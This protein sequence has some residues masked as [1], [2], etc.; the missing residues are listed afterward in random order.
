M[1]QKYQ[2]KMFA[3][4]Y[5]YSRSREEAE[6]TFHEGFMKV[7]DN[8][9]SFAKKGSLEGWI[10]K[11]MV[12]TAIEKYRKGKH[13]SFIVNMHESAELSDHYFS[14]DILDRIEAAELIA[15]IQKL[16]PAYQIVFNLYVMEG[17]KHK[18]ISACLGISEGT[19][20]SNLYEAKSILQKLINKNNGSPQVVGKE[21]GR[22]QRS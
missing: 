4:C 1:Y 5:R 3:V 19:S 13:L 18:E 10:R 7:F 9:A 12:N 8:I 22:K 16:P 11:I 21:H 20:K 17:M 15:L 2:S 6:D 14:D